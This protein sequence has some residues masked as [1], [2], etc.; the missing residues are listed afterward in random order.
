MLLVL[1]EARLRGRL[2]QAMCQPAH[3]VSEEQD[4][5]TPKAYAE[6]YVE[7]PVAHGG[8]ASENRRWDG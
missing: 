5:L 6:T 2:G 1:L 3:G 7:H 8:G 4:V